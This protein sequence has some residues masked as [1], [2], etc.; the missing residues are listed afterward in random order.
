VNNQ[1]DRY[2]FKVDHSH[3]HTYSDQTLIP[4]RFKSTPMGNALCTRDE[5]S[6]ESRVHDDHMSGTSLSA[7]RRGTEIRLSN[8]RLGLGC[9]SFLADK[10]MQV[11]FRMGTA[12]T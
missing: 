4:I 9:A 1:N 10:V 11:L 8:T 3:L 2:R 7:Q 12:Y 6:S 5:T